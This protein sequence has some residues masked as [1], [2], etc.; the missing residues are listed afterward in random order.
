MKRTLINKLVVQSRLIRKKISSLMI[1]LYF[2]LKVPKDDKKKWK[3]FFL[4][5]GP[6]EVAFKKRVRFL[7]M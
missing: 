2:F 5:E 7:L 3:L 4:S 1:N 6:K